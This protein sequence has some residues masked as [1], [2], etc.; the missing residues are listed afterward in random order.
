VSQVAADIGRVALQYGP[1]T[2]NIENVDYG[3]DV[4]TLVL[5]PSAALSAEW[6]GSLLDGVTTIKGSFADGTSMIAIPHYARMNRG[7]NRSIVWIRDQ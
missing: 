7:G 1:L 6:N 4:D 3:V 5:S 2:Y